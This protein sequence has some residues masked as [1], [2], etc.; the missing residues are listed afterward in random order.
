MRGHVRKRGESWQ[1]L[2]KVTDPQTGKQRQ[3]AATRRTKRDAETALMRM[4]EQAGRAQHAGTTATVAQLMEAWRSISE[5][6][7]SPATVRHTRERVNRWIIPRIGNVRVTKL[8]TVDL[9][10]LY[11]DLLKSG[12][13]SG[14]PLAP[15]SVRKVHN[16]L[17]AALGQ[18]VRWEWL[19]SNPAGRVDTR[20]RFAGSSKPIVPP[21]PDV[22]ARLL[23]AA[24]DDDPDFGVWLHLAAATG[25]RRGELCALRWS[26]IDFDAATVVV[27]RSIALGDT[28][29]EKPT[30]TGNRRRVSLAEPTVAAL[31]AHRRR[32]AERSLACGAPLAVDAFVFSL[33]VDCSSPWRPDLVSHR[34]GRL[35]QQLDVAGVR[36]H[37]LRHFSV[38]QLLAAGVDLA[39]VA[40]RHGHA[41]GGRTTLAVYGHMLES[42]DKK[43]A[44]ALAAVVM[45]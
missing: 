28:L 45:R 31:R 42:A 16:D 30:K 15:A 32:C 19:S 1:A 17:S 41:G 18:A 8:R 33:D 9:E 35:C 13:K 21:A 12:S 5:A 44:E 43:A 23:A 29:V 6:S 20:K 38:T 22:V 7:W 26:D 3:M 34:F 39:T 4:L 14:G 27:E 2:V 25:A 36:L 10:Q 37:D 24:A 40:A 11:A